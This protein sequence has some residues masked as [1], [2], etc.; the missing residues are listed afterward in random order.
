MIT[1]NLYI[2][3]E[4]RGRLISGIKKAAKAVGATM[5][6]GGSNAIIE[7]I[8]NPGH[9]T[10]NDGA[11]ILGAIHFADPIE[12]MG[13]K[14]LLES[15]SR[16]NKQSG[17]GSSTTTVLTAAIIEEGIKYTKDHSPMAIKRSL[18]ECVPVLE[19]AIKANSQDITVDDVAK[20]ATISAED[21]S[22]GKLIQEIYS[23][24]G[25][26][27]II[28]WDISKTTEDT[29]TI[30][31]GITMEGAGAVSPYMFDLDEKTGNF[32]QSVR[33]SHPKVMIVR[34]KIT[35]AA[36]FNALFASLDSNQQREV[37]IFCDEIEPTVVAD[38]IRTRAVRGF[39]TV[40]V[41]MPVL[42]KDQWYEDLAQATGA[43][44]ID[45]ALGLSITTAKQEDLG[46]VANMVITKD[47]TFMDGIRDLTDHIASIKEQGTDEA[48]LRASRLNTR[49][50]RLFI[51]AASDSALSY[52]RLKVEDAIS[53]AWQSLHGGIVPG[54]GVAMV[55]ASKSLS[56][57]IGSI[58]L[59]HALR[60]PAQQIAAN[61]G[62][63]ADWSKYTATHGL[64][65]RSGQYVDMV[66][67]N[68]V[69][70][71]N[72]EV[73]AIKNAVSVAAAV[74]TASTVVTLPRDDA[75]Y[76]TPA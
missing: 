11:T 17:D 74:L 67:S 4:A 20:V 69:N 37:V 56:T 54:G 71:T 58:I 46:T 10:T 7:A 55:N 25:A 63:E 45:P 15:V 30:G 53:A 13:R 23:Q 12:E 39:K 50:A 62:V 52:K 44:I 32:T 40:V 75:H 8:E 59:A 24:I 72:V 68:I 28:H 70:P 47:D 42:W 18:E 64:D 16:A 35:S 38:L 29:Y 49:T 60:A 41:K 6:T 26:D 36:D 33:W 73:N 21:E 3:D 51:G 5:G 48:E 76:P 61:A 14:I 57:S 66:E 34:Q 1:D 65:S 22:I 2:D 9:L 27:G 43:K 19:A 31:S